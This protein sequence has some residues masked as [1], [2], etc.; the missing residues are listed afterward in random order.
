M[1]QEA[2]VFPLSFAQQRLWFLDQ[3][4]PG[5]SFYNVDFALPLEGPL[6]IEALRRSVREI[7][8][9]HEALRTTFA[10]VK[11]E[12]VQVVSPALNLEL[13]VVD[14]RAFAPGER[15]AK[16]R[17]LATEEANRPFNL[18]RGPLVRTTLLQLGDDN[19]V[20]LLTM[21]H[22]VCDG[23]SVGVFFNELSALYAA[24]CAGAPSPL[25]ELP[26][27][28]ADFAVWQR[29]W[30]RGEVLAEQLAYWKQQLADLPVLQLPTDHPRP[31]MQSFHGADQTLQ[32]SARLT[33]QLQALSQQ[34]EVT[35]FMT[36]LAAFQV[37]LHRYTGQTDIVVGSPI[38]NRTREEIEGLIG[39]FVNTL[40]LRTDLSGDPSFREAL[41][42]VRRVAVG[43]YGR[44]DLPFEKLVEELQPERDL[45]RN[46]LFQVMIQL[47]TGGAANQ[48]GAG[49]SLPLWDI[50]RDTAILDL[51]VHFHDGADGLTGRVEY[52]TDLFERSTIQRLLDHF[53]ILLEGIVANPD[54]PIHALP[55]LTPGEERQLLI[56][57][58]DTATEHPRP[59]SI[60]ALF[61]EQAARTP[62]AVAVV[63]G[64]EQL[65]YDA[66]NRRANQ[67]AHALQA[68]GVGLEVPVGLCVEPSVEMAV[69]LLGILKAG[70][71]YVPL[72]PRY[73]RERLDFM[74]T[75]SG[76]ALLL[77]Q[78]RFREVLPETVPQVL[79]IDGDWSAVA[80][81]SEENPGALTSPGNVAYVIYTSGSTG[82]PK[83][84]AMTQ[85]PLS[86][87]L[88]W[89]MQESIASVGTRTLQFASLS[90]DVSFQEIFS[91]WS[92]GGTLVIPTDDV[93]QDPGVLLRVLS[94]SRVERL[95]LPFVALQQLA[96]SSEQSPQLP[97]SLREVITAGEQLH[98]TR[99]VQALFRRPGNCTLHNHYG[100]TEAHVVTAFT[101]SGAP[102]D[103][104]V[105]PPIGR[106][107][108]N[109]QVYV[110]DRHLSP[111]P[112]GVL[113]Q[114]YLGG[115]SLA[116]GY[117]RRPEQ[118][119]EKFIPSPF[120]AHGSRLYATG[121][122]VR[123]QATGDLEFLGRFDD[124]V[125]VRGFRVELGEIEAV[126]G[127]HPSVGELAVVVRDS[128]PRGSR[129]VAYV[130]PAPEQ[131]PS[132]SDLRRWLQTRLPEHMVPSE[133][134]FLDRLPLTPSGKVDR[135]ALPEPAEARPDLAEA[136]VA[137]RNPV[138]AVMAKIWGEILGLEQVGVHDHFFQLGGHSLLG[139][140]LISRLRETFH[141]ELP[142]RKLFEA[143]TVALLSEAMLES[144]SDRQSIERRAQLMLTL[145]ALSEDEAAAMLAARHAAS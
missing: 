6:D 137:P 76:A 53:Q 94:E 105:R 66:L 19:Y 80:R 18:A 86:N 44:Q 102:E 71:A 138:E 60:Q 145:S 41:A 143:P 95:F 56:D 48:P 35:L 126:L 79:Y 27:Q 140:R 87:L 101:L 12:P 54:Q 130:V 9:R 2:Y 23:W 104:P 116:R 108:A 34:E 106:P 119:A 51:A 68:R 55:L 89:Q 120:G 43:A 72:D 10:V 91:T 63:C 139:T 4:S 1:V 135:R 29:E 69:A 83:G 40:V 114:L 75:D 111:V 93:Q 37:L 123:Y 22:I 129:L 73:P 121:D 7:I 113:G 74:L 82:W 42:R 90:F 31:Q 124:Q 64:Q 132:A 15:E 88:A 11:R 81:A 127:R 14:L 115:E 144:S 141:V 45:S 3:L 52:S 24:F 21:H 32:L 8:R 85:G 47:H 112:I 59:S 131:K 125:K 57:W 33:R 136:Y 109:T 67:L 36:L 78:G 96:E 30:L 118:T 97:L 103:W 77:T 38:A 100:P 28:Y 62:D 39:F 26:I 122:L 46:P 133:F 92:S 70:G 5:N 107:I 117:T 25:P 50:Q 20:F 61:E 142:I 16:A 128:G 49:A 84:V 134:T 58:N 17:R 13:P 99:Q 98:V 110:L 65:S